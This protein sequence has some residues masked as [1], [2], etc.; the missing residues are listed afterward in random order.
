MKKLLLIL[1][2]LVFA[3]VAYAAIDT[4]EGTATSTLDT[5]EGST[6]IDTIEGQAVA[7]GA[8]DY[9]DITFW[10]NFE[11]NDTATPYTMDASECSSGDTT[12]DFNSAATIA[13]V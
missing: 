2:S 6:N 8:E 9:S 3:V 12:G 7:G 5:Y 10:L 11:A 1:L 4:L 13:I